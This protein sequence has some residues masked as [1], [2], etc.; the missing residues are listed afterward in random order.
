ML[1]NFIAIK[2]ANK[3]MFSML[4]LMVISSV[5]VLVSTVTKVSDNNIESTKKSLDM[6]NTAIFQSLRNSMNTGDPEQIRLSEEHARQIQGVKSLIIAK[7]KP[8]IELYSPNESF[9]TDKLVLNSFE[10]KKNKI[11][12]IENDT[13]HNMRLI[14]PMIA[15]Q[16]CL[17]CHANQ[18]IGDVV[19]VMDLTFSLEQ[20]DKDLAS[21]TWDILVWSTLLGWMTIGAI[22]YVVKITMKPLNNLQ[23][24]FENLITSND[25]NTKLKVTSIDE[26]GQVA[27]LFNQYMD[28]VNKGLAQ[29]AIVIAETNDVLEKTTHGFFV[30]E[31]K[32]VASNPNVEDMKNNL[33]NMIKNVKSILDK[34][35]TTLRFYSQSKY[36]YKIDDR[37]IYGDLGAV[38]AGIKLVGNNTSEILS[39]ILNTGDQLK[40]NTHH[41]SDSSDKLSSS[42]KQQAD[43]G[44]NTTESL[45]R[46]TKTIQDN[47]E[48]TVKMSNLAKDVTTSANDGKILA[49]STAEA[50]DEIGTKVT[51]INEA[52]TVIDQIAFQTNILSLNAAVEAATAGEAGKGFAVVAQEVRNL[53]NRSA[54]AAKDIKNIVEQATS[55]A[56]SGKEIA[57][58]MISGYNQLSENITNTMTL[59][60]Q[61]AKSS[62]EQEQSIVKI[63]IDVTRMDRSTKDNAE[64]SENIANMSHD[65]E[66]MSNRL[67]TAANKASFLEETRTQVCDVDLL[68]E[69]A[70]LK[71]KI[72]TYKDSA[73]S[74]LANTVESKLEKFNELDKWL[75]Q[76][77]NANN[78]I[79]R[80]VIDELHTMNSNL[81]NN[82]QNLVNSS[83]KKESNLII[84][85][86]AK[87]VEV[88][89]MRIFSTLNKIK[90]IRCKKEEKC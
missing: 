48:N 12:E 41:L 90:E 74:K 18:S 7:S 75:D 1:P 39:M 17:M 4:I 47:S 38:T 11:I 20:S 57:S 28:Q 71:V 26:I 63:N 19:G 43:S 56:S 10:T 64:V 55:K 51:T 6:L 62:K 34:I 54:I 46:L 13:E 2:V 22:Y 60:N 87:K 50:M 9:T 81:Y 14:K 52:I 61:V 59:I 68:Y 88:E 35:N 44:K 78:H 73:Y 24:G 42:V 40:L 89:S 30:Y 15:T 37:G 21:I 36:D 82:L 83:T 77:H 23:E 16:E 65:I 49:K 31:V 79:D 69:I 27:N 76:Y 86:S 33:N 80:S 58:N 85:E 25:T 29:D 84:N 5:A 45:D 67:V 3:I 70:D 66:N 53:A 8:L 72:F 32:S